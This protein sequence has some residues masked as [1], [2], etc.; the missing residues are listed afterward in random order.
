MT[1]DRLDGWH[2]GGQLAM[3]DPPADPGRCPR[4]RLRL[5]MDRSGRRCSIVVEGQSC[6]DDPA[7]RLRLPACVTCFTLGASP[8]LGH[9]ACARHTAE[10]RADTY[11]SSINDAAVAP[12]RVS[13]IIVSIIVEPLR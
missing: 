4:E 3:F 13:S 6:V 5:R 2:V 7:Y 1:E 9:R 12:V 10:L 8:C 11:L